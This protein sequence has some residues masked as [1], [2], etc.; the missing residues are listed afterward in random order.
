MKLIDVPIYNNSGEL[1]FTSTL[2]MDEVQI[3][4]QFAINLK[5]AMASQMGVAVNVPAPE[6]MDEDTV[7]SYPPRELDD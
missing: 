3:L 7:G 4:L 2:T 5:M 6:G 1:Q